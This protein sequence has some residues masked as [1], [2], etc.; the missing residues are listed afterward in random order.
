MENS[1]PKCVSCNESIALTPEEIN[2]KFQT[3]K[4]N[5]WN[6]N[7]EN[8]LN[9]NFVCKNW[10]SAVKFINDITPIVES[11]NHHPDIQLTNYK[12]NNIYTFM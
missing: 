7:N 8:K 3:L 9:R 1:T 2:I 10:V 11:I 4:S 5:F 6:I 12:Y